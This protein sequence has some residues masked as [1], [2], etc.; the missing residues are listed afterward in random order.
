MKRLP[1]I[2]FLAIL[3]ALPGCSKKSENPQLTDEEAIQEFASGSDWFKLT[4]HFEGEAVSDSGDTTT[5]LGKG[6]PD[7]LT[8]LWGREIIGHP[9]SQVTIDITGDSAFV[10]WEINTLGRF[11]ILRKL[12]DTLIH[13]EKPLSETAN[14]YAIFKRRGETN[15]TYR[16]WELT[17]I[18]GAEGT[19][20]S[21][22]TVEILS[23][24]IQS[25][26][27]PDTTITDPLVLFDIEDV[28]TF[29]TGEEV[30]L[31]VETNGM[32][33]ELFLHVFTDHWPWHFRIPFHN[34]EDGTYTGTWTVQRIPA[35]RFAVFDL[36]H[37]DTIYDDSYPYD[38]N[39]WL[40]PYLTEAL[41]SN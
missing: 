1:W 10:S 16:G 41:V 36:L 8:L 4:N 12:P 6:V 34:E 39:G 15:L 11:H 37:H 21:V 38:F 30:T 5:T 24:N 22:C 14:L 9:N 3:I 2:L 13:I 33:A 7:T 27:Y 35:V 23:V 31:T 20:D 26:S 19:S 28:L 17:K 18:S 29:Q 32:P 40:F 25:E